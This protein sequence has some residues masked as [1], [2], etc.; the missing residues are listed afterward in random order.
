MSHSLGHYEIPPYSEDSMRSIYHVRELEVLRMQYYSLLSNAS[1]NH[2]KVLDIFLSHDW[3]HGIWD[4]GNVN[5]LLKV[6]PYFQEDMRSGKL[7]SQPLR[8]LLDVIRPDFWF[9][10]H[11]H[12][13]FPALYPH[14]VPIA[15]D[16][17][18]A[19]MSTN[20]TANNPAENDNETEQLSPQIA[21]ASAVATEALPAPVTYA[22]QT[23]TRF[24]AL[25][26]IIPN[27]GYL[28]CLEIA[29]PP[30][31]TTS[32][33]DGEEENKDV[34]MSDRMKGHEDNELHFDI[35]WYAIVQKSHTLVNTGYRKNY[36][37]NNNAQEQEEAAR[38]AQFVPSIEVTSYHSLSFQWYLFSDSSY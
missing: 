35:P 10:A 7:G 14:Y 12:V 21:T 3:P 28:Q 4:Y 15:T 6:K 16:I 27:R 32:T 36:Y 37:N 26:K 38:Q 34:M 19:N 29:V 13:K 1:L 23:F 18:T 24:L 17:I 8:M 2:S 30:A 25:D 11:L 33:S 22:V 5:Q 9:A 31:T 20:E